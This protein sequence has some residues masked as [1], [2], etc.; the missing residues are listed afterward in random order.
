MLQIAATASL[1]CCVATHGNQRLSAAAG[2]TVSRMVLVAKAEHFLEVLVAGEPTWPTLLLASAVC[3][4]CAEERGALEGYT[5]KLVTLFLSVAIAAKAKAPVTA[6]VSHVTTLL[7]TEWLF[8]PWCT[9][10][11]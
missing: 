7:S 10:L 2:R 6:V 8:Q 5:D 1:Y 4:C 11:C 3:G 9:R